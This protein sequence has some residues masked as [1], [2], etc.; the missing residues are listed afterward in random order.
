MSFIRKVEPAYWD[1]AMVI[2]RVGALDP[3]KSN[4]GVLVANYHLAQEFAKLGKKVC[5]L[6]NVNEK[7]DIQLNGIQVF[8]I[9]GSSDEA[10]ADCLQRI[11]GCDTLIE[12]SNA[13]ACRKKICNRLL[14]IMHNRHHLWGVEQYGRAIYELPSAVVCVSRFSLEENIGWGIPPRLLKC[15]PNGCDFSVFSPR[16]VVRN[17]QRLIFAG[18][19]SNRKGIH[20]A[21]EAFNTIKLNFFPE[22]EMV[23]CGKQAAWGESPECD[24]W[25]ECGWVDKNNFI[26]WK[27]IQTEC[28]GLNYIGEISPDELAVEF[29]KSSLLILPSNID[30][31]GMVCVEAQG[32]GCIPIVPADSCLEETLEPQSRNHF[33][34]N[35]DNKENLNKILL[36]ALNNK[37]IEIH[38]ARNMQYVKLNFSWTKSAKGYVNLLDAAPKNMQMRVAAFRLKLAIFKACKKLKRLSS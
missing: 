37:N 15:I 22:L 21:I 31:F 10:L 11:G 19:T 30:T 5:L 23:V 3:I 35:N 27:K 6:A 18:Y 26:D 14:V 29:S 20:K 25:Q 17:P 7:S 1:M 16:D 4:N 12:N 34:F 8:H 33:S 13:T 36:Q 24:M 32:C 38:R 9:N 28:P 2:S